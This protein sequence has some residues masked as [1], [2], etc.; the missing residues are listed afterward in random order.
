MKIVNKTSIVKPSKIEFTKS[1]SK[2]IDNLLNFVE[3]KFNSRDFV[4]C[5]CGAGGTGKTF[6]IKY[7]IQNCSFS[8]SLIAC[9]APT[10]KACRVLSKAIGGKNVDTIQS[11]LGL[12][13]NLSLEDFDPNNPQFDP[14]GKVKLERETCRLLIIDEASM[15]PAKLVRYLYDICEE[16]A[17]KIIMLGDNSQLAPVNE[18]RSLAFANNETYYLK[19]IVR[20]ADNNPIQRLLAI[21]RDDVANKTYN[22]LNYIAANPYEI[23]EEGKGYQVCN[24]NS[25]IEYINSYFND[26]EYTKNINLNRIIAYTNASVV[27]WNNYV[28]NTIIKDSNKSII[29]KHDLIMS[30]QTI[31]DDFQ[32]PILVNSDEYII[33]EII[34]FVDPDYE[35]KGMLV[36][37]QAIN[38][39]AITQ[40][41]FIINHMDAF[42]I[43][44]YY[45]VVTNLINNAKAAKGS[46]LWREYYKFKRKYIIATNI[47]DRNGKVIVSRDIDYGFAITSHRSQGSTYKN[48]FVDINDIVY[49]KY[50]NPYNDTSDLLRRLYVACS[51]ASDNLF[52]YYGR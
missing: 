6:T 29:N 32:S 2:A 28:R 17:I 10:H 48:V 30:Y 24:R 15:L 4:R 33:K 49:D 23:N 18:K 13:L 34:D 22:F 36:K 40:P 39:G 52:L 14:L 45:A 27:G 5:L 25:F 1:Q 8:N 31:V 35:F 50:G 12:R 21:L 16:Q 47:V 37:F 26:E 51:R 7:V 19:E 41:L 46:S 3:G 20:Q 44:S 9:A 43:R 11:L 38:G 42:S